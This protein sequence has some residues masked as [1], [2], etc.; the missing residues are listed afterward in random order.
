MKGDTSQMI[1][2]KRDGRREEF[3]INKIGTA[4]V[5]AA[6]DI[7]FQF[8]GEEAENILHIVEEKVKGYDEM[9]I[10]KLHNTI[11]SA[12]YIAGFRKVREAYSAYRKERDNVREF[13][14]DLMNVIDKIGVTTD[15]DNANVGNNFSSKLLRIASES[16]KWHNL[17]KMPKYMAK[18]HEEGLIYF[19]D[20]DSENLT[21][22]CL[23]IPTGKML[24]EGFNTGYGTIRTPKR[25]ESAAEL[26][27]ILLQASQND[28]FGGQAHPN[29]DNDM[30]YFV[31]TTRHE[32]AKELYA[33]HVR[34]NKCEPNEE[35]AAEIL[36][37]VEDKVRKSTS[38]A[39]QSICYN[40]NS[41]HSRAGSQVP[42]SSINIGIPDSE[43]AAL[44]CKLFLEEYNKGMGKG[45]QFI[46]PQ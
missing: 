32:I 18:W 20:L 6:A 39:M 14:S 46:F 8:N 35:Q 9:P 36:A 42:F 41:M 28:M 19:H 43:D 45:E 44:V 38:Q 30:A 2:I 34:I 15:R 5:K 16:N 13:K 11:E 27:C 22:N 12:L 10:E 7:N 26:T 4:I 40:L 1:V 21:V 25:I 37:I 23:H 24:Q 33:N 3:D 29:F 31:G 17:A